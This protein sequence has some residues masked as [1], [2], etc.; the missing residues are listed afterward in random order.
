MKTKY[1]STCGVIQ[2]DLNSGR[3][4]GGTFHSQCS[5]CNALR[6]LKFKY[7][8]L[9][10]GKLGGMLCKHQK[11]AEQLKAYLLIREGGE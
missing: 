7:D 2:T 6:A 10:E 3:R 1:C 9:S 8:R 11:A 5:N 4:K